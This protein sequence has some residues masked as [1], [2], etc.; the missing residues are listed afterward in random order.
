MKKFLKLFVVLTLVMPYLLG[1]VGV[2]HA[3]SVEV[4]DEAIYDP[5]YVN[6]TFDW[7]LEGIPNQ[8]G[9]VRYNET[10]VAPTP[11][12]PNPGY[13]F[14]GWNPEVG[15]ITVDTI[16]TAVW[17][18]I[19]GALAVMNHTV[20]L[21]SG[22]HA[23]YD[24][25]GEAIQGTR[26]TV[27][28]TSGIWTQIAIGEQI[29]WVQSHR[30]NYLTLNEEPQSGVMNHT[31]PLRSGSGASYASL[32]DATLGTNVVVFGTSLN[33]DWSHIQIGDRIGWV[34]THRISYLIINEE[35]QRAVMNHTVPLR[36]GPNATYDALETIN[37]GTRIMVLAEKGAWTEIEVGGLIGWVMAHRHNELIENEPPYVAVM[38]HTI[39]L[40]SGPG[41]SY[42]S[43]G[44]ATRGT[45]ITVLG[46]TADGSWSHIQIGTRIGW[47]MVHRHNELI[48]NETSDLAV[49]N[50]TVPLR[51]GPN[52][53][54]A[55][56]GNATLGTRITVLG[57]T[58]D[59]SWSHIQIG[60][61]I[62]WVMSHRH[63][64]LEGVMN[65]TVPLR[66]GPNATY[67]ALGNIVQGTIVSVTETSGVWIRIQSD[68]QTG[69]V[70]NHRVSLIVMNEEP[71][72]A[73]INHTVPLRSGSG[74][75]YTM[76]T[77]ATQG[78]RVTVFGTSIDGSW[79]HIQIGNQVGWVMS[80]R[81]N[82]LIENDTPQPGVM[83]H[84]VPLRSGPGA[85]Y[86]S[87]GNATQGADVTVFGTSVDGDWTHIQIGRRVGWVM[88][89]RLS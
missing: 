30:H 42:A 12:P 13:L 53:S 14:A 9:E 1:P 84:T 43:L 3:T 28:T 24:L 59:G 83:N 79:S 22:P 67:D 7:G 80:H 39:P 29:G 72:Q 37:Q 33:G 76:L 27:L 71:Y 66:S 56:L 40:R 63:M 8:T 65:H 10:P 11:I 17:N 75:S 38:N 48:E 36:S 74:A 77:E 15:P 44:N 2:V 32:G 57:T 70:Q 16:F 5:I 4:D 73:V 51:S 61:R 26:I 69:W 85:S 6:Y 47:V 87:L 31:V 46:T 34:M 41:A 35:P 25:L 68:E 58:A 54:Y 21:R 82:H 23:S 55:S 50:H 81:F 60:T 45:R 78:L 49:M 20:P 64:P 18:P 52:A 86:F 19:D 88:S 62:G 89:H